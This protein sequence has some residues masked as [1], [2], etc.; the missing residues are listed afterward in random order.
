MISA[1]TSP[2]SS[3]EIAKHVLGMKLTTGLCPESGA[4]SF[5]IVDSETSPIVISAGAAAPASQGSGVFIYQPLGAHPPC[6]SGAIP[7][8]AVVGVPRERRCE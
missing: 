2:P 8:Y 4:R 1:I 7:L 6:V 5:I 3:P